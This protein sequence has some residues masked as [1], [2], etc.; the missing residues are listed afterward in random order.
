[1][2][3]RHRQA[4]LVVRAARGIF[5]VAAAPVFLA[6]TEWVARGE[7]TAD[8]WS[9]YIR[10]H[11][12]AYLLAGGLLFLIWLAV[13]LVTRLAPLA[14]LGGGAVLEAHPPRRGRKDPD[15]LAE[16]TVRASGD[17]QAI[18]AQ[19]LAEAGDRPIFPKD[20][21]PYRAIGAPEGAGWLYSRPRVPVSSLDTMLMVSRLGE[22]TTLR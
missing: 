9:A 5:P 21:T 20:P 16:L 15:R 13:D 10:P 17:P 14:T 4:P 3:S 22:E 19:R 8:T 12:P 7:L 2:I 6:L 11:L 1:M 18:A